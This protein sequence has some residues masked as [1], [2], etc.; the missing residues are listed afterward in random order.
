MTLRIRESDIGQASYRLIGQA[1]LEG[2]LSRDKKS[3][4]K[5]DGQRDEMVVV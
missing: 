3:N 4:G 1:L 2:A 5:S